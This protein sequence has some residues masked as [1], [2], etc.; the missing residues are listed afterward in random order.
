MKS[1]LHHKLI[2]AIQE[3]L[4]DMHTVDGWLFYD[5][6]GSDQLAYRVLLL[7]P[8]QHVTRRW[9]YWIPTSGEPVKL[10]HRIEPHV[11]DELPGQVRQYVSWEQQRLLLASLLRGRRQIAMQYSPLNAV[12]Y[13]SRV[14]AGTIEL[15]RSVGPEVVTSADLVQR[16]EAVWTDAQLESHRYAVTALRN[17]VDESFAHVASR[18]TNERRLSEYDL[19]QFILSRIRDAGM[20]TSSAPIAAVDAHSADPHYGPTE[21]GASLITGDNLV[22][23][24]LWAKQTAPDSVYGDITWTGYTGKHVP[25]KQHMIFDHV[26]RGRDAA[27]SFVQDQVAAGRFP[28]GWEVDDICR[29]AIRAAG[30]GDFFIHRTG[31][32]IGEE[33]HG[34]GANI[35]NLET[36][37][38]RRL[39]PRTC[40][41]IEPG[42]Y[43][44]GEFGIR[45][46]LDVYISD[47]EAVV[48]GLPLQTEIVSL[49]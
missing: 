27:L 9:Y 36:Q 47:R 15:I 44:P 38:S 19:Q 12:P 26:R 2:M 10:L 46:E 48:H 31:H 37:D 30:Y 21:S 49:L 33:V 1:S 18:V 3:T 4:R 40:F 32:S 35:D 42:I 28:C 5:F 20:T 7:D 22:L 29:N 8:T 34:N 24:D 25:A 16:F 41:S 11:L 14:D 23:I 6:R 43:L 39:L 17:I 45:S 13:L